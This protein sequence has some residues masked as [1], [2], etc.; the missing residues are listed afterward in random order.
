MTMKCKAAHVALNG[1]DKLSLYQVTIDIE[2]WDSAASGGVGRKLGQASIA[3][4]LHEFEPLE[5]QSATVELM[6]KE[7]KASGFPVRHSTFRH[8]HGIKFAS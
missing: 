8:L 5:A 1:R 4:D 7:K 2:L 6:G 3:L